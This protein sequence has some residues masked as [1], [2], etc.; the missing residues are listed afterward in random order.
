VGL[1]ATLDWAKSLEQHDLVLGCGP[2]RGGRTE[3]GKIRDPER[4]DGA[5]QTGE[6]A[7][8]A[9]Y[10]LLGDAVLGSEVREGRLWVAWERGDHLVLSSDSDQFESFRIVGEG[11]DITV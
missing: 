6:S 10:R 2:R 7:V 3:P 1:A 9:L 4:C 8:L 11:I 5:E